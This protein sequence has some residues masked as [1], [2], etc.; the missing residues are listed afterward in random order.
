MTIIS[1]DNCKCLITF[2]IKRFG[3]GFSIDKLSSK[4]WLIMISIFQILISINIHE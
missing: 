3:F 1:K 2:N 4:H